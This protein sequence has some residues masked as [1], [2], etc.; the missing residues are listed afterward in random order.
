MARK[1]KRLGELL[2]DAKKITENDL[3]RALTEQ[4]KYGDK[5][6]KVIVKQGLLSEKEITT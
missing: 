6:G 2:L 1:R 5:L 4:K 3:L